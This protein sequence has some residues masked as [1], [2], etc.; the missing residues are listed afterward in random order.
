MHISILLLPIFYVCLHLSG[1]TG[2]PRKSVVSQ[3]WYFFHSVVMK[4]VFWGDAIPTDKN[5]K[6][7]FKSQSKRLIVFQGVGRVV[8]LIYMY[9]YIY[10]YF[11]FA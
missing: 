6:Q 4:F 3:K 2:I 11:F 8:T 5:Y 1:R 10:I 9:I 7:R